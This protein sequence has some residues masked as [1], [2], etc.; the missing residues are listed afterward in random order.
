MFGDGAA[1]DVVDDD[2]HAAAAAAANVI[3]RNDDGLTG[4]IGNREDPSLTLRTGRESKTA[5]GY[6][7]GGQL[8]ADG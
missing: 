2:A 4:G 5:R 3:E 8:M 7:L 1:D 6:W